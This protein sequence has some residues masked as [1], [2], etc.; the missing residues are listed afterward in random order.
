M[1]FL[2][3]WEL[4]VPR[5]SPA[6][7]QAVLRMPDYAKDVIARKKLDKRYHVVGKHGGAWIYDVDSN[8]ELE[9]LLALA[10]VYNFARY[11]VYAL[12]DM[13]TP[14]DI[15]QPAQAGP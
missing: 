7:V 4:D 10:P 8:E 15:I 12:A 14:A 2:V 13:D 11:Q 6:L 5:M 9:R 1:K 3:M